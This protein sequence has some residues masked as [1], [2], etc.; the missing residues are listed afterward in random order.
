MKR[1]NIR[2]ILLVATLASASIGFSPFSF[3]ATFTWNKATGTQSFIAAANWDDGSTGFPN[4]V[5]DIADMSTLDITATQTI[6]V[7]QTITL[8]ELR[9]GDTVGTTTGS[10]GRTFANSGG[11]GAF[12]LQASSG[13]ARLRWGYSDANNFLRANTIVNVPITL[14]SNTEVIADLQSSSSRNLY[15]QTGSIS[16]SGDF[17]VNSATRGTIAIFTDGVNLSNYTGTFKFTS[18]GLTTGNNLQLAGNGGT[19]PRNARQASLEMSVVTAGGQ[20]NIFDG[21]N[22]SSLELGALRGDGIITPFSTAGTLR[23]GYLPGTNTYNGVMTNVGRF[24]TAVFS[25]EKAGADSTQILGG[26]NTY[27][28]TTTVSAGTLLVNGTNSGGGAYSVASGA[29]LGGTGSIG[30]SIVTVA[31]GGVLAPGASIESLDVGGA[32]INGKLVAEYQGATGAGNDLIDF[33][34]VVGALDITNATLELSSLGDPL[35]DGVVVL[36]KYGALTGIQFASV[37]GTLPAGYTIDYAYNDGVSSNNIALVQ[38]PEPCSLSLIA[39][40]L[41]GLSVSIRRRERKTRNARIEIGDIDTRIG[42]RN[43]K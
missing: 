35:D 9:V 14:N 12:V 28:G 13:N 29:T 27:T 38:V 32:V 34:N 23:T 37:T 16:G 6:N 41:L 36:A 31:A 20:V 18:N 42:G 39:G 43:R 11:T 26:A 7:A 4:A 1:I 15:F 25:Y 33:L 30:A 40:A 22:G 5:D 19:T 2:S 10:F 3:A 21:V 17:I 24:A 8:G